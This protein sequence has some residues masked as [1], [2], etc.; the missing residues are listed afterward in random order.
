M[1]WHLAIA[2]VMLAGLVAAGVWYARPSSS[3]PQDPVAIRN[4]VAQSPAV[5]VTD[6]VYGVPDATT[7]RS[8][9]PDPPTMTFVRDEGWVWQAPRGPGDTQ[10]GLVIA[11]PARTLA[12]VAP[13]CYES[14]PPQIAP[15]AWEVPGVNLMRNLATGVG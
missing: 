7:P 14:I 15:A 10:A 9:L 11:A 1:R 6:F 8:V 13:G 3:A 2:V 4:Q 5:V 12:A